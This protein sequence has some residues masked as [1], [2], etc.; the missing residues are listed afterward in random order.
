MVVLKTASSRAPG[1]EPIFAADQPISEPKLKIQSES[2]AQ[3]SLGNNGRNLAGTE[4]SS[5]SS[6]PEIDFSWYSVAPQPLCEQ[7]T[8]S[9]R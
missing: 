8:T 5:L 9:G 3:P 7:A 4:E 6:V 2:C 1:C